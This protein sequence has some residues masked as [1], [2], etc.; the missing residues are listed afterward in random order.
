MAKKENTETFLYLKD[1]LDYLK[2]NYNFFLQNGVVEIKIRKSKQ[3]H[4]YGRIK[5]FKW[6]V[7]TK[8]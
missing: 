6:V 1:C 4:T 2:E 8:K 3:I 5:N 7:E